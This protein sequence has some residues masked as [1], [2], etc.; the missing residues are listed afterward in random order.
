MSSHESKIED[1]RKEVHAQSEQSEIQ[2]LQ[3]KYDKLEQSFNESSS[4]LFESLREDD[5]VT[6]TKLQK[7]FESLCLAVDTWIEGII[8]LEPKYFR[9]QWK[10]A[11]HKESGYL[12]TLGLPEKLFVDS[13]IRP[14]D[15][16]EWLS[17]RANCERLVV[18]LLVWRFIE[19]YIFAE[20]WPIGISQRKK[21]VGGR[22]RSSN[23][24]RTALMD[25]VFEVMTGEAKGN[26]G[27]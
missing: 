13:V 2:L 25:E 5:Q 1:V 17:R 15:T 12:T 10:E 20:R 11:M 19:R 8:G 16:A 9:K 22:A 14:M 27:E 7:D 6:D 24:E 21:K 18:T 26:D 4:K 23:H 3:E